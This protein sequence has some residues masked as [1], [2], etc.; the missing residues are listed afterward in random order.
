MFMGYVFLKKSVYK[1]F[2]ENIFFNIFI[3]IFILVIFLEWSIEKKEKKI[4]KI[5]KLFKSYSIKSFF[6]Y[7]LN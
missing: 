5:Y 3:K 4:D 2:I 7:C 6:I 1:F